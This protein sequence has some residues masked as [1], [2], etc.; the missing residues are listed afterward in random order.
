MEL[1]RAQETF[2]G[3]HPA[4]RLQ[5]AKPLPTSPGPRQTR[6]R[7]FFTCGGAP[8]LNNPRVHP[9]MPD[10]AFCH[11]W[12]RGQLSARVFFTPAHRGGKY[13]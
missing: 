2:Q 6:R 3:S 5:C 10:L 13:F 1:F 12:K 11:A 7:M 9:T 8:T 4:F